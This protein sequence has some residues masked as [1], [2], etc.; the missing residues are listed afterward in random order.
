MAKSRK[1]KGITVSFTKGKETKGTFVYEEDI[2]DGEDPMIPSLYI[3][4]SSADRF[5]GTMPEQLTI[6]IE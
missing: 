4:K 5:G 3:R 2:E 6:T 1:A